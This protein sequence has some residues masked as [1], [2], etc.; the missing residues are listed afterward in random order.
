[1]RGIRFFTKVL[2]RRMNN[3]FKHTT[4]DCRMPAASRAIFWHSYASQKNMP[5]PIEVDV[6][7]PETLRL[8]ISQFDALA[9]ILGD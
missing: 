5:L 3:H 4:V 7:I 1:M 8:L 6:G 9:L 2:Y